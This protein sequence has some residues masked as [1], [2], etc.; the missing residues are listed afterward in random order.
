[1]WKIYGKS[2][3]LLSVQWIGRIGLYGFCSN[4][5]CNGLIRNYRIFGG[6]GWVALLYYVV[7]LENF[8][9]MKEIDTQQDIYVL[10]AVLNLW[11]NCTDQNCFLFKGLIFYV[12]L[13]SKYRIS[14]Q[15]LSKLQ[16]FSPLKLQLVHVSAWWKSWRKKVTMPRQSPQ[17]LF[18][19]SKRNYIL[20][21]L[22]SSMKKLSICLSLQF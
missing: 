10:K 21:S 7:A 8:R 3:H 15:T 19:W 16:V 17:F 12:L 9:R 18:D 22:W 13:G 20:P 4:L 14:Q 11:E 5:D 1:M 2:I 6:V